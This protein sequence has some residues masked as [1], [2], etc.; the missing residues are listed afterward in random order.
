[1]KQTLMGLKDVAANA[2]ALTVSVEA[3]TG[4]YDDRAKLSK[5]ADQRVKSVVDVL[6]ADC[7]IPPDA[8]H[9]TVIKSRKV[10]A[11]A[12]KISVSTTNRKS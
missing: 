4:T 7:G 11:P 10:E 8:I 3:Y 6:V 2:P 1:M 12:I 5:L 9:S